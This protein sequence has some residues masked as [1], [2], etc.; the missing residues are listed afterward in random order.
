MTGAEQ[1]R[2][3]LDAMRDA[4]RAFQ[5]P[6]VEEIPGLRLMHE[7]LLQRERHI[8]EQI[9]RNETA[10][11]TVTIHGAAVDAEAVPA[12]VPV[13]V[14]AALRDAVRAAGRQIVSGWDVAPGDHDVAAAVEPH[15]AGSDITGD[16]VVLLLTRPPGP[17]RVQLL[18]PTTGVPVAETALATVLQTLQRR[19][20]DTSASEP[21]D[22]VTA[23]LRPLAELLTSLPL[24]L[25]LSLDPYV[26][27]PLHVEV[28]RSAAQRL[29]A[30]DSRD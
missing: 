5:D 18:H 10:S 19:T 13:I 26:I 4:L 15:L 20:A 30:A 16:D 3:Q 29:L 14:L 12:S 8:A 25:E 23:A 9:S 1:L 7:T 24:A 21:G 17:L 11:L 27:E 28:D 22:A 6:I 2:A